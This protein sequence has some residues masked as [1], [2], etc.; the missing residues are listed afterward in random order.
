MQQWEMST[1]MFHMT[2]ADIT[3]NIFGESKCASLCLTQN[4]RLSERCGEECGG[5]HN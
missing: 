2:K 3:A 5:R 4:G 1:K